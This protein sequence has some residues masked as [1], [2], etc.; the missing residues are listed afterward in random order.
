MNAVCKYLRALKLRT[1]SRSKPKSLVIL[2]LYKTSM[3]IV[4]TRCNFTKIIDIIPAIII[5]TVL[6]NIL[7]CD[8][9]QTVKLV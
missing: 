2:A 9:V 5:G 6:T 4:R 7:D 8:A 3:K 1:L